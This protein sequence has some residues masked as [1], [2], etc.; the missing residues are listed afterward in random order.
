MPSYDYS[1]PLCMR[2]HIETR[3]INEEQK[4]INCE[5]CNVELIRRYNISV[6]FK[7]SGFYT[8]DKKEK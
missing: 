3:G 5:N 7:G 2:V 6:A 8:T 1:C 4:Q